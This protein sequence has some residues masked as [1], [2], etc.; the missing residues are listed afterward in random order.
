MKKIE[1]QS[2]EEKLKSLSL[3]KVFAENKNTDY[4]LIVTGVPKNWHENFR[5]HG[6]DEYSVFQDYWIDSLT[7]PGDQYYD[8]EFLHG[9]DCAIASE[10]S[11]SCRGYSRG[12]EGEPLE[13]FSDWLQGEEGLKIRLSFCIN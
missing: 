3:S 4:P 12:F 1:F 9:D 6:F 7:S 2:I 13:W 10:I 8:Y 11:M 5:M